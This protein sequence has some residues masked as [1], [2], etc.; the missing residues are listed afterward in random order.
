MPIAL[1]Q[2]RMRPAR[3]PAAPEVH[4]DLPEPYWACPP[5]ALVERL[6]SGSDGLSSAEAARRLQA[7]GPNELGQPREVTWPAVLWG[8]LRNPL[9]L[10][11]VFAAC[12]SA[13]T[14]EWRDASIVLA[15]L[16]ASV[17]LGASR[18]HRAQS[19]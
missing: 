16:V 8:Q 3:R 14:G 13:A 6:G 4:L 12:A 10:L 1:A 15:I 7:L 19:A 9:L 11:L 18:E 2:P 5:E 17:G